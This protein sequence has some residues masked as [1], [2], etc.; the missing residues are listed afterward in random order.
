MTIKYGQKKTISHFLVEKYVK[1]DPLECTIM[2]LI[3]WP[4][5]NTLWI[6]EKKC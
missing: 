1:D 3:T 4:P 5:K 6:H 2:R